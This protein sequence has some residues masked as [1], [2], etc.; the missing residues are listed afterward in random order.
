[1][2]LWSYPPVRKV[3]SALEAVVVNN[4]FDK[5]LRKT[6]RNLLQE[7][8][9]AMM[10]ASPQFHL[11]EA[12]M[13]GQV[14]RFAMLKCYEEAYEKIGEINKRIHNRALRH[15]E[16]GETFPDIP[17]QLRSPH[18]PLSATQNN[19]CSLQIPLYSVS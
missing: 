16:L 10:P 17:E 7:L 5:S 19:G 6:A 2:P 1:M 15:R 14:R 3:L 12:S 13:P 8:F 9:K 11:K 4:A 18:R